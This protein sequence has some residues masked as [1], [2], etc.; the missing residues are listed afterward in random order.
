MANTSGGAKQVLAQQIC[1]KFGWGAP[2]YFH[3]GS[4]W[5]VEIDTGGGDEGKRTYKAPTPMSDGSVT[6][7]HL[8][9]AAKDGTRAAAE[10]AV[11]ALTAAGSCVERELARPTVSFVT[12]FES[13]F[14]GEICEATPASWRQLRE[15]MDSG[16]L[17]RLVGI[18]AEG[19][20]T[21]PPKMVQV[22]TSKTILIELP[23]AHGKL[24]EG[25]E[26]LLMD[27][28]IRKVFCDSTNGD[29][30]CL[31]LPVD[32]SQGPNVIELEELTN[33]HF[34]YSGQP[35]GLVKCLLIATGQRVT[36]DKDGWRWFENQKNQIRT[37]KDVPRD[38]VTYAAMDAWITLH[39]Y[40]SIIDKLNSTSSSGLLEQTPK[41]MVN[42]PAKAAP[43]EARPKKQATQSKPCRNF[44]NDGSCRF[45][46]KC[47]FLHPGAAAEAT[48]SEEAQAQA[49][50]KKKGTKKHLRCHEGSFYASYANIRRFSGWLME[51]LDVLDAL[52][53]AGYTV[54]RAVHKEGT[55]Q[56]HG[57]WEV[58]GSGFEVHP[59]YHDNKA[60]P[61][62]LVDTIVQGTKGWKAADLDGVA[63]LLNSRGLLRAD[64]NE[65]KQTLQTK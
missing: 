65:P 37:L 58:R 54:E 31:G 48:S 26:A 50:P 44:T 22:A 19:I 24:S 46:G 23:A 27:L 43:A 14:R 5:C 59:G 30:K 56:S 18:D 64:G 1:G 38:I 32:A 33:E 3:D 4:T 45:G 40:E 57:R 25:L 39:I 13:R 36:K 51:E 11:A 47:R 20:H 63:Q 15:D 55:N 6:G 53:S 12:I 9:K 35:R 16:V 10:V 8:S 62:P 29:K 21:T 60:P 17:P 61:A 49:Q 34:G 7:R 41:P 52:M 42:I 28:S 2:D